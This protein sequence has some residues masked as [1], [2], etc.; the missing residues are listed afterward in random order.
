MNWLK[1]EWLQLTV[2]AAPFCAAALL[3]DRL[4]DRIPIH[5]NLYWQLDA[6]AGKLL[7]TLL[8]PA[9]NVGLFLLG[10]V[11]PPLDPRLRAY[12]EET[13]DSTLRALQ[14]CLLA[15]TSFLCCFQLAILAS[16]LGG[17]INIFL[18][19]Q[20]GA[21]LVFLVAG[22]LLT[23]VRPNHLIGFRVSW[24]LNSREVWMKTHRFAGRLLVVAALGLI[25]LAFV[26]PPKFYMLAVFIPFLLLTAIV[27]VV[28]AYRLSK[29]SL[30]PRAGGS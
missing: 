1:R 7:G 30:D 12:D 27:P 5:W 20:V 18:I 8:V 28:Y 19:V 16:A 10:L 3:W 9:M 26:V 14:A 13:R 15:G 21:A 25:I 24:T 4:P 11:L 23:K 6:Y 2:L 17:S 22:N 29:H